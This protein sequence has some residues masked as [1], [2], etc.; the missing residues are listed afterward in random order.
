M[1]FFLNVHYYAVLNTVCS[2]SR[3][4]QQNALNVNGCNL[5]DKNGICNAFNDYFAKLGDKLVE[6]LPSS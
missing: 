6:K 2:A 1:Q 3:K 5:E 4:K